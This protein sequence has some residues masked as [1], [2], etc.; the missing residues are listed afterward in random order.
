MRRLGACLTLLLV[1]FSLPRAS[2]NDGKLTLR[3]TPSDGQPFIVSNSTLCSDEVGYV[4]KGKIF[5]KWQGGKITLEMNNI[6][7]LKLLGKEG[8][9]D[10]VEVTFIDGKKANVLIRRFKVCIRGDTEIG[11]WKGWLS[12]IN[13]VEI[14]RNR[15]LK[16]TD[17]EA[18]L[19]IDLVVLKNGDKLSGKILNDQFKI[20]TSYG[21]FSFKKKDVKRL[22]LEG[23]GTNVDLVILKSGD[24]LSGSIYDKVIELKLSSGAQVSIDM[25]RVKS[26]S[27]G[28]G[29]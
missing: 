11:K 16:P 29:R 3:I 28:Q 22:E 12:N 23:G 2:V 14:I 27:V 21:E 8:R 17:S 24:R 10:I 9:Y 4:S 6:E 26:V 15:S 7:K 20:K 25:S 13:I 19:D 5:A 18:D 1:L